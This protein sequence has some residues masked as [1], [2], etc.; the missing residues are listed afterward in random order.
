M[1]NDAKPKLSNPIKKPPVK[2][3]TTPVRAVVETFN[4]KNRK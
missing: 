2:P 4:K 3:S 1:S